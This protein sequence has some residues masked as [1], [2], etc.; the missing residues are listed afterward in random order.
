MN[1]GT[2]L[3]RYSGTRRLT[4]IQVH[5]GF[6]TQVHR[7]TVTK[8]LIKID[9]HVYKRRYMIGRLTQAPR[10]TGSHS[11]ATQVGISSSGTQKEPLWYTG[12]PR[13]SHFWM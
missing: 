7:Y 5:R 6:G 2:Q 4:G 11:T 8:T 10:Y 1:N 12:S 9:I 13:H 3:H